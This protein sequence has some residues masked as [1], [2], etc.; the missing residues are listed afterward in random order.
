MKVEAPLLSHARAPQTH[1]CPDTLASAGLR[2]RARKKKNKPEDIWACSVQPPRRAPTSAQVSPSRQQRQQ[3][4]S[5]RGFPGRVQLPASFHGAGCLVLPPS[6]PELPLGPARP[7]LQRLRAGV[8]ATRVAAGRCAH[9]RTLGAK[10]PAR[11]GRSGGGRGR[12]AG[13]G[14]GSQSRSRGHWRPLEATGG[15]VRFS[16]GTEVPRSRTACTSR[17]RRQRGNHSRLP[18]DAHPCPKQVR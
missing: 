1:P 11:G 17:G 13:L 18:T 3:Q 10:P 2:A 8:G 16:A 4:V 7:P 6:D 14:R 5:A 9:G 15:S 12:G